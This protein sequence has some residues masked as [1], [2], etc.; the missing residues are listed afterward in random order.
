MQPAA[1]FAGVRIK[2]W[3]APLQEAARL[4]I[5]VRNAWNAFTPGVYQIHVTTLDL[6]TGADLTSNSFRWLRCSGQSVKKSTALC[7]CSITVRF[8][9]PDEALQKLT[10]LALAISQN[11]QAFEDRVTS[12][13]PEL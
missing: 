11:R 8:R 1:S 6:V 3:P 5:I 9:A 10:P 7:L 2:T 4:R 12:P 13:R